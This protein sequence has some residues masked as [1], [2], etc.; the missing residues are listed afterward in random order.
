[1]EAS[2]MEEQA[3]AK[4]TGARARGAR[5]ERIGVSFVRG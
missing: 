1:M 5:N 4:R 3:A 2:G